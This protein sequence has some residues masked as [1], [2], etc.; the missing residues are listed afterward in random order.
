MKERPILFSG[1]MVREILEGRKI[2]TRRVVSKQVLSEFH[3]SSMSFETWCPYGKPGDRLWVRETWQFT[4]TELN[5]EPGYV[6]RATD[7]DWSEMEGWKWR[8]SIFMPRD[9]SRILLEVTGVRVERVQEITE[10]DAR[11]EGC[12]GE[13]EY[14]SKGGQG[15]V[16]D[17]EFQKLWDSI[18]AKRG[19][20]WESNPWVWVVS[21]RR[22]EVRRAVPRGTGCVSSSRSQTYRTPVSARHE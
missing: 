21:F 15:W 22:V 12:Q 2:Q 20:S 16:Y 5:V 17:F 1:P 10:D 13:P 7:P 4:G 9:A 19:Y 14:T 18:N 8:P 6:Y 3:P 11:A